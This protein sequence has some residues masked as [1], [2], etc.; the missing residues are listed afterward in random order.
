M[1]IV[2]FYVKISSFLF[3]NIIVNIVFANA[4]K[5]NCKKKNENLIT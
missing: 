4:K 2:N 3:K 1:L 5:Y